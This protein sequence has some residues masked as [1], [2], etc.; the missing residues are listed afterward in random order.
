MQERVNKMR[1]GGL[2]RRLIP[3]PSAT[4]QSLTLARSNSETR[5]ADQTRLPTYT[6]AQ[7]PTIG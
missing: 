7:T 4:P 3:H 5:N 6:S 2:F 1:G